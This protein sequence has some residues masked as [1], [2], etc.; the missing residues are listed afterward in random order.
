MRKLNN[1]EYMLIEIILVSILVLIV[2]YFVI[3]YLKNKNDDLLV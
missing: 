1:K 3:E 2:A